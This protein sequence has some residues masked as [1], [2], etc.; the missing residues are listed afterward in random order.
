ME[1]GESG[2]EAFVSG[3]T[4]D[5]GEDPKEGAMPRADLNHSTVLENQ[6]TLLPSDCPDRKC[7]EHMVDSDGGSLE[8][9]K[10]RR[11]KLPI[12]LAIF[13]AMVLSDTPVYSV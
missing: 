8:C 12:G 9:P 7:R 5:W 10:C 6:S 3:Y 13:D 4:K 11:R 1:A 2:P